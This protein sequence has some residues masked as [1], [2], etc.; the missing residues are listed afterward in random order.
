MVANLGS[1]GRSPT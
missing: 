1:Y